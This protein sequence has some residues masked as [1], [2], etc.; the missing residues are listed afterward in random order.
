MVLAQMGWIIFFRFSAVAWV[1]ASL[2]VSAIALGTTCWYYL[3]I[4]SKW[5]ANNGRL[6][7]RQRTPGAG[8]PGQN[9]L[10]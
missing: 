6:D 7:V 8:P 9:P 10:R 3:H 5:Q 1:S 4:D 2:I